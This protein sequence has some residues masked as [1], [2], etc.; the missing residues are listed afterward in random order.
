METPRVLLTDTTRWGRSARIAIELSNAG[1]Q[2]SA[3]CLA[4][5][6]PL[7]KTRVV[8]TTYPYSAFQPLDSLTAAIEAA[9]PQ[10]IIPCD[11]R[12]V[13]HLHQLHARARSLRTGGDEIAGLI[14]RSLGSPQSYPTVSVRYNLLE[15]ARREGLRVPDTQPVRTVKDLGSW[16][17]D[18]RLP[19]VL[20]ADR[21]WGGGGV[22]I[23]RT[24]GHA[25]RFFRAIP[26]FFG[27]ALAVKRLIVNRDPFW[28]LPAWN[29]WMPGIIVQSH[30]SGRAANC[31]V[32][33]WEG[34]VLA[35]IAA[36][37]ISSNKPTG[38]AAVVRIIDNS[39]MMQCAERLAGRL[40]LSGFF[41]LDFIIEEGTGISHLIEMNPRCTSLCHLRLGE[42][43]DMI[44]ALYAQLSG[45]PA[46]ATPCVTQNDMIA[47]FPEAWQS[48]GGV[49]QASFRDLPHSEPDLINELLYFSPDNT[50]LAR[51]AR[52]LR[53]YFGVH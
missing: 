5:R 43:R 27:K 4:R 46:P 12:A 51:A 25:E 22:E 35:G 40:G 52:Q 19:W 48:N 24:P 14:E 20:K 23:V 34:K 1:C 26:R 8:H 13:L 38:P 31:A 37:V 49:P 21:T 9:Q 42:G 16:G 50:L 41:G 32:V 30:I 36:E 39:E 53:G 17:A 7:S 11:D 18:H 33:C 10:I 28:L 15:I 2:V 6:H 47:Y 45:Q 44:G 3:V 29:R